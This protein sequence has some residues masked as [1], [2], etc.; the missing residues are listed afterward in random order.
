[1]CTKDLLPKSSPEPITQS[2]RTRSRLAA[3][4]RGMFKLMGRWWAYLTA[5]LSGIVRGAG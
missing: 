3:Y 4:S 1:M 2:V 5:K